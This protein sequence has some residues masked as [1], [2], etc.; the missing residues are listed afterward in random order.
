M[1]KRRSQHT[2]VWRYGIH[3]RDDLESGRFLGFNVLKKCH[4]S[5]PIIRR[6]LQAQQS[7]DHLRKTLLSTHL[8]LVE[9]EVVVVQAL[10]GN[11]LLTAACRQVDECRLM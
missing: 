2:G 9:F 1:Y 6:T 8:P 3:E 10:P 7:Q 4:A 11:D 5:D